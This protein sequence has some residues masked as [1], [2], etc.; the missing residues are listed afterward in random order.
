[1]RYVAIQNPALGLIM[2][3]SAEFSNPSESPLR[4]SPCREIPNRNLLDSRWQVTDQIVVI[5]SRPWIMGIVNATPD[6]FSDGG[7]FLDPVHAVEHALRLIDEGAKIIDIGGESTRPGSQ[8]VS[9]DEELRRTIPVIEQLRHQSD[10]LISI[11]TTKVAVAQAALAAGAQIVNDVSGLTFDPEMIPLCA[12]S[13]AGIICM[14]IQGT[15]QNMQENPRYA[16]VVHEV[17]QFLSARLEEL[18]HRGISPLQ[19]VTDPGIGFGKTAEH[20]LALLANIARFHELGRPVC[21]GHSRKRFLKKLLGRPVDERLFGTVGI[22][23][24]LALQ[25]TEILRVHDVAATRDAV[26]ACQAICSGRQ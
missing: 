2:S 21:V 24:A 8:P 4:Q 11:D 6:S 25:G 13:G 3:A 5:E 19:I 10:V 16:D 20:N 17:A 7:E 18:T 14:H 26:L 23:V 15:P 9:V 1:M 22:S 12:A